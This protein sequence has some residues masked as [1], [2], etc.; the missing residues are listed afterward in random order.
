MP[1]ENKRIALQF[2]EYVT[3][4]R[5]KDGYKNFADMGGKHHSA[6]FVAG[7]PTLQKAMEEN[8]IQF[9]AKVFK[10]ESL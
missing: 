5:V 9:P 3:S 4:G 10:H 6:F 1:V 7:F 8:H 2:M